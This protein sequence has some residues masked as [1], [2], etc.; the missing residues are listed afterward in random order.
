MANAAFPGTARAPSSS[1]RSNAV[2][3]SIPRNPARDSG[4]R[5]SRHSTDSRGDSHGYEGEARSSFG[6]R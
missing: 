4:G 1:A 5:D 2:P 6:S 3:L